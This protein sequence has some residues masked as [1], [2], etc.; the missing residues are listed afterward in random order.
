[1]EERENENFEKYKN[2]VGSIIRPAFW[3]G[4]VLYESKA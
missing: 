3:E 2:V 1:M 4:K